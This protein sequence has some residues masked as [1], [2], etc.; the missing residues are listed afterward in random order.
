MM[1]TAILHKL[2]GSVVMTLPRKVLALVAEELK[3]RDN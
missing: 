3:L 1:A 2:G